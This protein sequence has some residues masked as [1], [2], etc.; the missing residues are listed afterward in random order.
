MI[1]NFASAFTVDYGTGKLYWLNPP[2]NHAQRRGNEAGA[3]LNARGK[4]KRYWQ[5]RVF[6]ATFKRSRV[7]FAMAHGRWPEPCVD[8]IDGDSL[9]DSIANLREASNSQNNANAKDRKR[10]NGLPRGVVQ[11]KQGRFLARLQ[12]GSHRGR[13]LGTFDTPEEAQAV[14]M[15]A[16]KET[17][18]EFA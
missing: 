5:V 3:I 11:T 10:A 7:I 12:A 15:Q 9:N 8:H 17:F 4:N 16:K 6:G 1:P 18:G 14:Y 2:K 13:S